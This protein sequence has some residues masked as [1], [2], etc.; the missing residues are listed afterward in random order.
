MT[1]LVAAKAFAAAALGAVAA[2]VA[3][4]EGTVEVAPS[5]GSS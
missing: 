5:L 4:A 3:V 1:G 2:L